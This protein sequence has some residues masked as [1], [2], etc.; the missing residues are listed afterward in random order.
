[1]EF[2]YQCS[3][4]LDECIRKMGLEAHGRVQRVIDE[5]FLRGVGSYVPLDTGILRDSG[6]THTIIGAGEVIWDAE[7][8]ARRLYYGEHD[9]NWSNGG[10]Q[11]GG[12]RGPY[13]AERYF[14]NGGREQIERAAREEIKK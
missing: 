1:M 2:D 5:T 8:K 7:N 11:Q 13:W 4:N 12:L 6:V 10:V 3:F 9:W 14:Q